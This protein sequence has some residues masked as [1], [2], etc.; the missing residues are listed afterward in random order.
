MF[1]HEHEEQIRQKEKLL[2]IE[3]GLA[4]ER[5][6]HYRYKNRHFGSKGAD[7]LAFTQIALFNHQ[8]IGGIIMDF[9]LNQANPSVQL[10]IQALKGGAILPA[11]DNVTGHNTIMD[12]TLQLVPSDPNIVVTQDPTNP[13]LVTISRAN[14]TSSS[15]SSVTANAQNDAGG[16]ITGVTNITVVAD[17]VVDNGI[18]DA[19]QFVSAPVVALAQPAAGTTGS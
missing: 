11:V 9:T 13:L 19:L 2:E 14:N 6:P 17:P 7:A 3:I 8:K 18:A 4:L 5:F 15:A 16:S 1:L 12:G 10:L